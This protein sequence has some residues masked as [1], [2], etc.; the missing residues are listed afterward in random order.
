MEQSIYVG[1]KVQKNILKSLLATALGK[2]AS[3]GKDKDIVAV[4]PRLYLF[5]G[6]NGTGKSSMVDLCLQNA[7]DI[8]SESGKPIAS[9]IIDL[10]SWRFRILN[11]SLPQHVFP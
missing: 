7:A 10:D 11:P 4:V 5:Y 3:K 8:F 1:R 2:P 6:E 9:I